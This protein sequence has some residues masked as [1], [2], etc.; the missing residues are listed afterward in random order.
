MTV[1]VYVKLFLYN[2]SNFNSIALGS[3]YVLTG[4]SRGVSLITITTDT[5]KPY[6]IS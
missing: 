4:G 3:V 2:V 1:A 5:N 6:W